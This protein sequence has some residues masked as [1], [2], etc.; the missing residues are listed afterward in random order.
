LNV[1]SSPTRKPT[2]ALVIPIFDDWESADMLCELLNGVFR[3]NE[4]HNAKILF[5]N[6]GSVSEPSLPAL[7]RCTSLHGVQVL[8]LKRNLGHQRAIALGLSYVQEHL[9]C[10]TV[11]VM[12]G[13]G[14]DKPQDVPALL[15]AL[16]TTG[17][18]VV[19]AERGKRLEGL[20]FRASYLFYR[21]MHRILTGRKVRFGNFSALRFSSLSRLTVMPEIW[22]HYAASVRIA[23][24]PLST[25]RLDRG[26]RLR[27]STKMNFDSLVLHGL[28]AMALYPT[29]NARVLIGSLVAA[30]LMALFSAGVIVVR[31]ATQIHLPSW[32]MSMVGFA[33]TLVCMT[34]F[35]SLLFVFVGVSFRALPGVLPIRDYRYFVDNCQTL[36]EPQSTV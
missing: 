22:T 18:Q 6:D 23:G 10:E 15:N 5:V 13:D 19:F 24:L 35:I 33:L 34:T 31:V 28:A 7:E 27:G 3:D 20:L 9:P 29:I 2:V 4:F 8:N 1:K 12:D 16:E 14:E 30:S 25:I 32:I 36:R 11:V 26:T 17:A 21:T